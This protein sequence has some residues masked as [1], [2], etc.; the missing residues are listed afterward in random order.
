MA[1]VPRLAL[2]L[3]LLAAALVAGGRRGAANPTPSGPWTVT[4][5]QRSTRGT[6]SRRPA[7][8]AAA[9]DA[10]SR[11]AGGEP[12]RVHAAAAAAWN[13]GP[14]P[15]PERQWRDQPPAAKLARQGAGAGR[16]LGSACGSPRGNL[17]RRCGCKPGSAAVF[18]CR[19]LCC[20]R[21]TSRACSPIPRPL[22]ERLRFGGGFGLVAARALPPSRPA[23]RRNP[24]EHAG[25]CSWPD[26]CP[27]ATCRSRRR[28]MRST[29][30]SRRCSCPPTPPPATRR[31][32]T[33]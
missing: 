9:S 2:G 6:P 17:L 25:P 11:R 7:A 14:V 8:A 3:T 30:R 10:R 5:G 29:Q 23:A 21:W 31:C 15:G 28:R 32:L 16:L 24:A 20:R 12:P 22:C 19:L 13:L 18:R 27:A 4:G 33:L 26:L 1:R